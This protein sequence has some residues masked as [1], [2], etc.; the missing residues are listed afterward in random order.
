MRGVAFG[1][2]DTAS[3]SCVS[4]RKLEE[5]RSTYS[6]S[7][8][9]SIGAPDWLTRTGNQRAKN[10]NATSVDYKST[11]KTK[12]TKNKQ[13]NKLNKTKTRM[14]YGEGQSGETKDP[15]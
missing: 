14:E 2:R 15:W 3:P 13:K 7:F 6:L 1:H 11:S 5:Q 10:P 8:L 12:Q 9:T 4:R